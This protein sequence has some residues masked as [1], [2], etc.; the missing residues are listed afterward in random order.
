MRKHPEEEQQ[1]TVIEPLREAQVGP[2]IRML[3][4]EHA[5]VPDSAGRNRQS[6]AGRLQAGQFK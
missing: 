2:Q 4:H 6:R 5:L 1:A 3:D